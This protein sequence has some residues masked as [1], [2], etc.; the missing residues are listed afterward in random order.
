MNK[1]TVVASIIGFSLGLIAAITIWVLPR[2]FP[3][4]LAKPT[5]NTQTNQSPAPLNG[6]S[7][8]ITSNKD[9]DI[10]KTKT[11]NLVGKTTNAK[12][13][14]ITT[15]TLNQ[16]VKP[17]PNGEFEISLDLSLGGNQI[18]VSA[19]DNDNQDITKDLYLYYF[20]DKI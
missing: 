13:V 19:L 5:P 8:D 6:F 20:E 15:P 7:L 3:K 9:G 17:G 4:N 2:I 1:D 18:A 14:I 10:V 16:V 11:V 12:F